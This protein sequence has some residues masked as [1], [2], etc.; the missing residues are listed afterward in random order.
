MAEEGECPGCSICRMG[1][2]FNSS[3]VSRAANEAATKLLYA[4]L[5]LTFCTTV[6]LDR[7]PA[8]DCRSSILAR[9]I[10]KNPELMV[11]KSRTARNEKPYM[12]SCPR[13]FNM[14][15]ERDRSYSFAAQERSL[16]L[17]LRTL[18]TRNCRILRTVKELKLPDRY[19]YPW[20]L[21]N[22]YSAV[23]P[24]SDRIG[25][26]LVD[27]VELF[28]GLEAIKNLGNLTSFVN[29]VPGLRPLQTSILTAVT[30][31]DCWR[32]WDWGDHQNRKQLHYLSNLGVSLSRD[33]LAI[34]ADWKKLTRLSF[35]VVLLEESIGDSFPFAH[36]PSL[37]SLEL[38]G[39]RSF[40]TMFAALPANQLSS[41]NVQPGPYG[42]YVPEALLSYLLRRTDKAPRAP[43][44]LTRLILLAAVDDTMSALCG[45]RPEYFLSS[46]FRA[47]PGLQLLHIA[48]VPRPQVPPDRL[49]TETFVPLAKLSAPAAKLR[50][51]KL[52]ISAHDWSWLISSLQA[53][54]FP[55]L[56]RIAI[57]PAQH[58]NGID[59]PDDWDDDVPLVSGGSYYP[60][61]PR[62]RAGM[63]YLGISGTGPAAA[64]KLRRCMQMDGQLVR[65]FAPKRGTPEHVEVRFIGQSEEDAILVGKPM[66]YS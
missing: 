51:L 13:H 61:T 23:H 9:G 19:Q 27:I 39:A 32:E 46:L 37:R 29:L 42:D 44:R 49:L 21:G 36:L 65:V 28:P 33:F 56:A 66:L 2:L 43:Q 20:E 30:I 8:P 17:L 48:L 11:G 35:G 62:E 7:I 14:W 1:V 40:A 6:R 24:V 4:S 22:G 52:V 50:N 38:G 31:N 34:H 54:L 45:F 63:A 60:P 10:L 47:A 3:L 12:T 5:D 25:P 64:A 26:W 53:S 57:T 18:G 15:R 41:L 58:V 59:L 55:A 16:N